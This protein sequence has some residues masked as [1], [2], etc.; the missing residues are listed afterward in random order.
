MFIRVDSKPE[1]EGNEERGYL[2]LGIIPSLKVHPH[3]RSCPE[4]GDGDEK[5][6]EIEAVRLGSRLQA[7]LKEASD[8][9]EAILQRK[10]QH[11]NDEAH[12]VEQD[13]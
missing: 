5:D 2:T 1:A 8:E 13:D 4:G 10:I 6:G 9:I 7:K 12:I 11:L 3:S